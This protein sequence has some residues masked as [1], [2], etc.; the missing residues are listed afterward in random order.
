MRL[1]PL[2]AAV[3]LVSALTAPAAAQQAEIGYPR[4]SLG[5]EALASADYSKAEQQLRN[6]AVRRDDPA[7]LINIGQV[8]A[9]TGRPAEAAEMFRRAIQ[10]REVV[11]VLA[12]GRTV[13]SRDAATRALQSLAA[14]R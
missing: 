12:S 14:S 11:L 6:S 2:A 8:Y 13:S 10:A 7:L 1:L 9:R 5:F 3:S 4:G